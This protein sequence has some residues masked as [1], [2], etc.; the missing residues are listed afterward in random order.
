MQGIEKAK[1]NVELIASEVAR[2][3]DEWVSYMIQEG[4]RSASQGLQ[5]KEMDAGIHKAKEY[6]LAFRFWMQMPLSKRGYNSAVVLYDPA[7][8]E[9]DRFVVGLNS[10]EQREILAKVFQGEEETV[11]NVQPSLSMDVPKLYGAWT[12]LRNNQEIVVGSLAV[13]MSASRELQLGYE[14]T[15]LLTVP[16]STYGELSYRNYAVSEYRSG[17]LSSTTA[18]GFT[19]PGFLAADVPA[20]LDSTAQYYWQKQ[21]IN[22]I[23][24]HTVYTRDQ[25]EP[26]RIVAIHLAPLDIRLSLFNYIKT[27][28]IL[29]VCLLC[30]F[31]AGA[32][33]HRQWKKL[34][35]SFRFR[36]FV[37]FTAISLLPLIFLGY[38]NR[39]FASEISDQGTSELLQREISTLEQ[40]FSAYVENENDFVNGVNDDFCDALSS[41]Y[42]IDLSVYYGSEIQASSRS[43]L[44]RAGLLDRR[45]DGNVFQETTGKPN[46]TVFGTERIGLMTYTVAS[47]ALK[48]GSKVVGVL[49]V[50]M[51]SSR[52]ILDMEIAQRN[53][54]IFGTY[55]L[56]FVIMIVA[57]GFLAHRITRPLLELNRAA[58]QVGKGDLSIAIDS[59]SR[60]ELGNLIRSFNEM[61]RELQENRK[62]LSKAERERA[63]REMAKQVAHEIRNPI[64]PMKLSIQHLQQLFKDKA[65]LRE[66][67]LQG[68]MKS[69]MDQINAL[70]R[71]ATEFSNFAK[72]PEARYERFDLKNIISATMV[73]FSQIK[74]IRFHVAM[75]E[76]PMFIVA[77]KDQM[78][79]VFI[80]ILRNAVQ[81]MTSGG[82]VDIVL[83]ELSKSY[84]VRIHDSGPGIAPELIPKIFEPNFS[85]KTEG[86]GLGLAIV[87]KIVEDYGGAIHCES[88]VG[89]GTTF[90]IN[91][92]Q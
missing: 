24:F 87:R 62:N 44:Y 28:F 21:Y 54:F 16:S 18:R 65:P 50:P 34:I 58:Q 11:S 46:T 60:D 56:A 32:L 35:F 12:V 64:T 13:I 52:H 59:K 4:L 22:G 86:M 72:M 10:Y 74:D 53:A 39:K 88:I 42:G 61:T 80:N 29:F 19:V 25:R 6:N 90:E 92:P 84:V 75:P 78:Q 37:G 91:L 36:L 81:A 83:T 41:E 26:E 48:I 38:Y 76:I 31:V 9:I 70:S 49:S 67:V 89:E 51:L 57:T 5:E 71:I 3:A 30:T 33:K 68:V 85:T 66:D 47:K 14:E 69:M 17:I 73:L 40:R 55:L 27:G 45:L 77:D 1:K 7:G 2:P 23:V 8:N 43:E 82:T 79:R 15:G 20:K 63:W